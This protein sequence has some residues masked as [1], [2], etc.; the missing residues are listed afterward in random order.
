VNFRGN[1][2]GRDVLEHAADVIICDGFVGNIMLKLGESVATALVRMIHDE[3]DRQGLS[4]EQKQATMLILRGVLK[5]FDYQ[6]Y[7][8]APLLGVDGTVLIGHGG[9][10]ARAIERLVLTAAEVARQD[11]PSSITAALAP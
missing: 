3:M 8:G 9:S 11:I 5:Q 1:I 7:G 2:E 10:S 4:A 6:E